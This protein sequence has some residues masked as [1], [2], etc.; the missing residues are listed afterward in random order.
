MAAYSQI[1]QKLSQSQSDEQ[2][3]DEEAQMRRQVIQSSTFLPLKARRTDL[4]LNDSQ[5]RGFCKYSSSGDMPMDNMILYFL[6]EYMPAWFLDAALNVQELK[7][8]L[9]KQQELGF[10]LPELPPG[11]LSET[12]NRG[13]ERKSKW[14]TQHRDS[15][16]GNRNSNSNTKRPKFERGDS[17]SQRPKV[18]NNTHRGDGVVPKSRESTLL[19]KLLSSDIRR[20]RH[21]LL[22]TFKFMAMNNFFKEWPDKPL[23]FPSVKV[24]HVEISND[25]T[26]DGLDEMQNAEMIEDGDLDLEEN[27]DVKES[28]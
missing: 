10:E 11:Y 16:F 24:N 3:K 22:H 2:N 21:R 19:Q 27:G 23:E 17:Q 15:R 13:D 9:A 14:K 8:I 7:E 28:P 4:A 1:M 18:W 12:E 6:V 26:A 20:D 25:A 5:S